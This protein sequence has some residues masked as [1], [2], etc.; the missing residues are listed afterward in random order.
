[1]KKIKFMEFEGGKFGFATENI[2]V[3][4]NKKPPI[5]V[6]EGEISSANLDEMLEKGKMNQF[7]KNKFKSKK[8]IKK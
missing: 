1:M 8:K 3:E 5:R 2:G 7:I 4:I 6:I